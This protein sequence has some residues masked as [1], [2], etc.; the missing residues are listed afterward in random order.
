MICLFS[1]LKWPLEAGVAKN[2]KMC[3]APKLHSKFARNSEIENLLLLKCYFN[4]LLCSWKPF[5]KKCPLV[6]HS[7]FRSRRNSNFYIEKWPPTFLDVKNKCHY[8]KFFFS[9]KIM[10]NSHTLFSRTDKWPHHVNIAVSKGLNMMPDGKVFFL[11]QNHFN[12]FF[13]VHLPLRMMFEDYTFLN[14]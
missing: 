2:P 8:F 3:V 6:D 11:F 12:N 14:R 5:S 10:N 7:N 9:T 4:L 13:Q 1:D